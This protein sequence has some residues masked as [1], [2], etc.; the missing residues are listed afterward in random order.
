MTI[1]PQNNNNDNSISKCCEKFITRFRINAL[2]RK[3]NATKEK[4]VPAYD[5]FALLL[6]LIFSG[7]NLY[8]LLDTASEKVAFGKDVVYRFLNK[9]NI[10]WNLFLLGL[11]CSVISVVDELTSDERAAVL[12]LDDTPYYRDR[13]KKAELLSRFK[14][15]SENR[16][17]KGF[18]LLNLGWSDG[19][20]FMPADFRLSANSD[21]K[22]LVNGSNIKEDNRTL[23]TKRRNDARKGKP[24][25]ALDM[26]Q[27]IKG[28][29]AQAKYVLF[30]SWFASSSFILSVKNLG[31]DVVARLKNHKNYRY[32]FNGEL[33]SL[34][35]IYAENKKRRGR[36]RFLLSVTVKVRHN[37]FEESIPAKIVYVRDRNNPKKWIALISADT[38]LKEAEIITLY[39]K[40]WDIEPF[41]KVIKSHLKLEKEFQF[42]SFDAITAHT[43][44]LMSLYILISVENRENKD[45]RSV[46]EGFHRLC[47]ELDDI[48][49][50]AAFELIISVLKKSCHDYIRL[51]DEQI[52]AF[53]GFF[54]AGLPA[55]IKEKLRV[56]V[57]ES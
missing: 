35:E 51:A 38:S 33:L 50:A 48:S 7:K 10:N 13:S 55:F 56:L 11:S 30:D 14:D 57:C 15:H 12:I 9:A 54:M 31:Y 5:V 41:H 26:L 24:E 23:A 36:A 4:G 47:D 45:W 32:D 29:S 28:T 25:L 17:Y 18:E 16:Y 44:L 34:S 19:Q 53:V 37:D 39:G 2:L 22:K 21:D 40:R 3:S 6:G 42:R 20:T 52:D 27:K 46:N 43:A 1:I 8:T 49:F